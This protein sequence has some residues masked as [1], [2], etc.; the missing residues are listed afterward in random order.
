MYTYFTYLYMQNQ[1]PYAFVNQNMEQNART[2]L[3]VTQPVIIA[4][5]SIFY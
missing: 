5:V 3:Y 4:E 2:G 1:T